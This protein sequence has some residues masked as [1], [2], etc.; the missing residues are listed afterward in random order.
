MRGDVDP[1][2]RRD[3][4]RLVPSLVEAVRRLELQ[5]GE[6]ADSILHGDRLSGFPG[7]GL[8]AVGVREYTSGDEVRGIDWRVT[9]RKGRLHVKEFEEERDLP[10]LILFHRSPTLR[11]GRSGIKEVR[12]I[13]VVGLL[14][15]LVL[16]G[17]NRMELV[18]GGQ[19]LGRLVTPSFGRGRL[20]H[21]LAALLEAPAGASDASLSGLLDSI[22]SG[23]KERH[24]LFVVS[25][26]QLPSDEEGR[27]RDGLL[28]L[29]RRHGVTPVRILDRGEGSLPEWSLSLL[30]DPLTQATARPRKRGEKESLRW[31][32]ERDRANIEGWF[33]GH[34]I[35]EWSFDVS[36]ALIPRFRELLAGDRWKGPGHG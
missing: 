27:V 28:S 6:M 4:T 36:M 15:A 8:E 32:L 11:A 14:S 9:A 16:K 5:V 7:R 26:F 29:G 21:L 12:A 30:Q 34:G 33:R 3:T 25:D 22:R 18:Q 10:F 24:R 13:E 23:A 35:R 19:G 1:I 20:P 31:G 2:L 17:G